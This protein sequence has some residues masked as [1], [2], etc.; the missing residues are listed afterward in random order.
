MTDRRCMGRSVGLS[1]PDCSGAEKGKNMEIGRS[2]VGG[3]HLPSTG[4][5]FPSVDPA[6][7][8]TLALIE[9]ATPQT[10]AAALE[11]AQKG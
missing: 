5:R 1:V 2:W 10:L 4:E 3:A 6:T 7:G 8:E 9:S 11:S